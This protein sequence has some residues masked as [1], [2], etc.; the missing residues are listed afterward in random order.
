MT[1]VLVVENEPM[2]A[3]T[4]GEILTDAGFDVVSA[5]NGRDALSRLDQLRPTVVVTDFRMPAMDGVALA[6]AIRAESRFA[7]IPVIL[8]TGML[9]QLPEAQ[10]ALFFA[11]VEKPDVEGRLLLE[12]ETALLRHVQG[13]TAR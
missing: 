4:F 5:S 6:A 11:V 3:W 10:R 12:V 13:P 1:R 2:A 8:I 7:H 9:E